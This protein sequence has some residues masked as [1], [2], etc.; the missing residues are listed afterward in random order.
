MSRELSPET[1]TDSTTEA[2]GRDLELAP[3]TQKTGW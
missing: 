3:E 2:E 1:S